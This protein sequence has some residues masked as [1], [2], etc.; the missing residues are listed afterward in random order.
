M[1][2]YGNV[3][4]I[5]S[6]NFQFDRKYSNRVEMD[7]AAQTD[8]VYAGRYVLIE[9]GYRFGIGDDNLIHIDDGTGV[10]NESN[11]FNLVNL[12]DGSIR[13][14]GLTE[15]QDYRD[16]AEVDLRN[17]GA[18][19]D[20]TVWQKVYVNGVD[21][22]VMIA[23]LNASAPKLDIIQE[24][25]LTYY[26]D[27][28]SDSQNL[29]DYRTKGVLSGKFN[30]NG[31]LTETVRLTNAQ[32]MYNVAHF[33]TALDTE[34]TYV[35]HT[36]TTLNLELGNDTV[37]YN[38]RGFNIVYSYPESNGISAI[39]W[40]PKGHDKNGNP[41][42]LD[43][44]VKRED[45]TTDDAGNEFAFLTPGN[46]QM[47]TKALFMSFPAL[48]NVMN[49]LYNL[50]YGKPDPG[51]DIE[52]GAMRPYFKRYLTNLKVTNRA[53]ITDLNGK[54]WTITTGDSINPYIEL[55][56]IIGQPIEPAINPI[57]A[58][59][60]QDLQP[61]TLVAIYYHNTDTGEY[62]S[63]EDDKY[64]T[65]YTPKVFNEEAEVNVGINGE[66]VLY[67]LIPPV[68]PLSIITHIPTGDE[69]PDMT[70]L[71]NVPA[72]ADILANNET[73]LAT[74]L[75]SLFGSVDP[76]DGST[77]YYLYNDWT[78]SSEDGGSGPAIANKPRVVGGYPQTFVSID[79][80]A[81]N[82]TMTGQKIAETP[83]YTWNYK[84][85]GEKIPYPHTEIV[86]SS[87]FSGG[88]Y[89]ID[90]NNWQLIDYASSNPNIKLIFNKAILN[91]L[92]TND[93]YNQDHIELQKN[94]NIIT[95]I[96]TATLRS[97]NNTIQ[98][99]FDLDTGF[100]TIKSL[101]WEGNT[102]ND[103]DEQQ[104]L[105]AGLEAGHILIDVDINTIKDVPK[106]YTLSAPGFND[107]IFIL[108]Y[109][110]RDFT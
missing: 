95:C 35:L 94:G 31:E 106:T 87:F 110:E 52:H 51:D 7:G 25:P 77:K 48:G 11:S 16:N 76:L 22:Y 72:L 82:K 28:A 38:E 60:I 42:Y 41:I 70:W 59:R 66:Y 105:N 75:S 21:K 55:E 40:I 102:L 104:M 2:L 20:S 83:G 86:T 99:R 88:T 9:Y 69:D 19:Y 96:N 24:A 109:N 91:N 65:N 54:I 62:Y 26:T 23:E 63:L 17:Y 34:L 98:I 57:D 37:D 14:E 64:T 18:V 5:G 13:V 33:D 90:F 100:N 68:G 4:R 29:A 97:S 73:G 3:K 61:S 45:G 67:S 12:P 10:I 80:Y 47:D 46:Y 56:G 58:L 103:I 49:A 85:Y 107:L 89:K 27:E 1:S 39:A 50:L 81:S 30:E 84:T 32:E 71:K 44:Y 93:Q 36:P 78:M 15:N 92:S 8:G 6:A 74:T 53:T 101:T 108:K 43:N 79:S